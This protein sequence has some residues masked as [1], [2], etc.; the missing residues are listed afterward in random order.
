LDD[1][2]DTR[3]SRLRPTSPG[4]LLLLGL[5]VF[6]LLALVAAAS[7]AHHTPGGHAGIHSPPAGV[8]NYVFTI[9][10]VV[11]VVT[12][13]VIV[14]F[15]FSERDAFA[16]TRG[17]RRHRGTYKALALIFLLV[18]L[19]VGASRFHLLND[20][21]HFLDQSK[22]HPGNAI[23]KNK[24]TD[25]R[26]PENPP[27]L[28]WL[29]IFIAAAGGLAVLGYV[30]V[31]TL[32]RARGELLEQQILELK[33]EELLDD[34]LDDLY[35][36]KD[37]RAA[38]IAAYSK[39]EQLFASAGL[40][41]RTSEAPLEY[42]GRAL[43]ELRASGAALGRLTGLFQRA[44]FSDHAMDETM[45]TEAIQA[46]TEV[47]DELRARREEDRLHREQADAFGKERRDSLGDAAEGDDPFAAAADRARGDIYSGRM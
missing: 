20:K 18:G 22:I 5:G 12:A 11:I 16:Q 38:I 27:T 41:R 28:E 17:A 7:R 26:N 33:F 25:Q 37:P 31:R 42:L 30:G 15:W 47:R 40:P 10:L 19:A 32:R 36:N 6:F 43:G 4:G 21:Q 24:K 46:L 9:F 13:C 3:R 44:K 39:M 8:G 2:N 34:T 29:P 35:A 23:T 1:P 14:Y 45:R